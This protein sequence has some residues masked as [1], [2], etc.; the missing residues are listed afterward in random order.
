MR[1]GIGVVFNIDTRSNRMN[2]KKERHSLGYGD[3]F[4]GIETTY[5]DRFNIG[6]AALRSK[7]DD[8]TNTSL[9]RKYFEIDKQ[10]RVGDHFGKLIYVLC[11]YFR[12]IKVKFNELIAYKISSKVFMHVRFG[13]NIVTF[14][15]F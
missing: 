9:L 10:S 3:N 15:L 13:E 5:H 7:F 8:K 4:Y 11:Y 2:M 12:L 1:F 14:P 6:R